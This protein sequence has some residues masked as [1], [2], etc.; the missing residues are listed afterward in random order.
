MQV[1]RCSAAGCIA[2]CSLQGFHKVPAAPPPFPPSV[3]LL[4]PAGRGPG[5]WQCEGC[6]QDSGGP[7]DPPSTAGRLLV[8]LFGR[9]HA[10]P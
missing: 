8:A 4:C 5:N 1:A 3:S 2:H 6:H 7:V 10:K 9:V